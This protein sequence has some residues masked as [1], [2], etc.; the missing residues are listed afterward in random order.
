MC[1]LLVHCFGVLKSKE[2]ARRW[3]CDPAR[4]ATAWRRLFGG[5]KLERETVVQTPQPVRGRTLVRGL[6]AFFIVRLDRRDLIWI[7]V[8]RYPTAEWIA[9][10]ITEAFPWNEAPATSSAIGTASLA[11]S[12]HVDCAPW[13]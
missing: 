11:P 1:K 3:I 2:C 12:S 7:D 4:H 5:P 9:R 13:A 10:Q 6:Y 8:T